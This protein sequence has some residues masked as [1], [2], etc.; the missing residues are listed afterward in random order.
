[1]YTTDCFFLLNLHYLYFWLSNVYL[2]VTVKRKI[3]SFAYQTR[4]SLVTMS[5]MI[6]MPKELALF[7]FYFWLAMMLIL[8]IIQKINECVWSWAAGE[9]CSSGVNSVLASGECIKP[10][11]S[12]VCIIM[13]P[14]FHVLKWSHTL[15]SPTHKCCEN[16]GQNK[17][18][19]AL[20]S[21]FKF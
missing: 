18:E 13:K 2:N 4:P 17:C 12:P 19:H 21:F 7:T 16:I 8:S 3:S 9:I 6:L 10:Q 11:T 20:L 15:L 1:M 14:I 5:L